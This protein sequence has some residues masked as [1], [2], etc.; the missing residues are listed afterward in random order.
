MAVLAQKHPKKE[1]KD[2]Y[3]HPHAPFV[4]QI[5]NKVVNKLP[6]KLSTAKVENLLKEK[7]KEMGASG[8]KYLSLHQKNQ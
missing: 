4:R 8:K 7:W 1:Q 5:V 3:Q 6:T 2:V